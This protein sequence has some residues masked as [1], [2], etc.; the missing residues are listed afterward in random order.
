V[1]E[2]VPSYAALALHFDP[3][4]IALDEVAAWVRARLREKTRPTAARTRLIEIPVC[5]GGEFGP[6]LALLASH[7]GLS[8]SEVISRHTALEYVVAM[9]GFLPGFPYLL[10]LDEQLSMPRMDNP[11]AAVPAGAVGIGGAQTGIYP[12]ASPGGWRLIA[13]TPLRL[14][15]ARRSEPSLLRPGDRVRFAPVTASEFERLA[16]EAARP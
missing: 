10:G 15:D 7:S 5:Y 14:F 13:R 1:Q 3:L 8:E 16:R 4:Q 2:L 12:Q 9:I 11:R 6:D